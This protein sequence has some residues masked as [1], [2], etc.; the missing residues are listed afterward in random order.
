MTQI[1]QMSIKIVLVK[2]VLLL[3]ACDPRCQKH[4]QCINGTCICQRGFNG[5]HC[6]LDACS[7]NCNNHGICENF[8]E[9]NQIPHYE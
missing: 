7:N 6:G 4:G 9:D 5:R 1:A 2:I 3:K 8:A